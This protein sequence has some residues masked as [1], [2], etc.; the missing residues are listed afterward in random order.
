MSLRESFQEKSLMPRKILFSNADSRRTSTTYFEVVFKLLEI[1]ETIFPNVRIVLK[2]RK[3][4][5]RFFQK[6]I[7][8]G[9]NNPEI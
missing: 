1:V 9:A 6:G 3:K 5:E 2:R 4:K 7:K 8:H